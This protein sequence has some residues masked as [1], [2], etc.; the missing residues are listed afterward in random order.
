M[1]KYVPRIFDWIYL[2]ILTEMQWIHY[3]YKYLCAHQLR[4]WFFTNVIIS[5]YFAEIVFLLMQFLFSSYNAKYKLLLY[6]N[7]DHPFLD[8]NVINWG[9]TQHEIPDQLPGNNLMPFGGKL[10]T[11]KTNSSMRICS[12]ESLI[13]SLFL[14]VWLLKSFYWFR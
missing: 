6:F 4:F 10:Q 11:C 2:S 8:C 1:E 3:W 5:Y 9:Y 14:L 12:F 7:S 13:W